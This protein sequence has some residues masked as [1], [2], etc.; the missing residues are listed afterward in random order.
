MYS[1]KGILRHSPF[2]DVRREGPM[3][4]PSKAQ[5]Q[6]S[7]ALHKQLDLVPGTEPPSEASQRELCLWHI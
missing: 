1:D 3:F 5:V 2:V 4:S 6:S 7:T